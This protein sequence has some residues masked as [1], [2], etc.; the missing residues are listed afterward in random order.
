[1]LFTTNSNLPSEVG[2]EQTIYDKCHHDIIYGSTN[3]N[4]PLPPP[5]YR[6]VWDYKYTDPI[7][8]KRAISLVNWNHFFSNTT[9]DEKVKK[10][11][12]RLVRYI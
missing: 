11:Q 12:Q 9:A 3:F 8:I 6:E 2:V 4:L 10:P 7:C 5:Y 1:M